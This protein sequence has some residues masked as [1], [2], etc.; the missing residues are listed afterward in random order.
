MTAVT[1]AADRNLLFAILALQMDFI[2]RDQ[3]VA[4]M[5]AWVLEKSKPLG[6]ILVEQKVLRADLHAALQT[7]VEKH[8]EMHGQDAAKSL[9]ALSASSLASHL[10]PLINVAD[11]DVQAS[12]AH[13]ASPLTDDL[14]P[15]V[16][17]PLA[18]RSF[19]LGAASSGARFRILRPHAKGGLGQ[20]F[21][22]HDEELNR[23][24]ALKDIQERFA[25]NAEARTRFLV[26]AEIT[27]GLE[28][29]GIVPVYGLGHHPDGRPF[30]AMRFIR[31]DSLKEAI[32]RYHK[33]L[34]T[35]FAD[36][37]DKRQAGSL[38]S[39]KS[40]KSVD[41]SFTLQFRQLLGRFLDVCNAVAYAHSR[42][43]LHRDLKPGNI[44]L[45]KFG[46][47]L[48]VDWGLAKV[49]G[50]GGGGRGEEEEPPL[51]PASL[52]G[53]TQTM[54]GAAV[55]TPAF[56]SP[57]QAAG[58]LDQLGPATDIY[59]LGATLYVLLTG[60]VP[61]EG[62]DAGEVLRRVQRGD[63]VPLALAPRLSSLAPLAAICQKAMA[64]RPQDRYATV[65]A[66]A[67]DIE[68]W[69]ADEPVSA[70]PEPVLVK[71]GR[72]TRRHKP[73]VSGAAAAL[74]VAL[75]AATAGTLW[76]QNE[77]AR[78]AAD[79]ARRSTEL[80]L[81]REYLNKEVAQALDETAKKRRELHDTLQ[82]PSQVYELLSDIDQWRGRVREARAAWRRARALADGSPELLDQEIGARLGDLE[83]RLADDD[84]DWALAKELD[85]VRLEASTTVEGKFD[86]LRA[87]KKYPV[88]FAKAGLA[89]EQR[90]LALVADRIVR[91][92]GRYA[93]VAAL[94]HWADVTRDKKLLPLLLELARRADSHPWRDRFR[95]LKAWDDLKELE[96]LAK[97]ARPD[98]QSPQV[99]LTL[100]WRIRVKGGDAAEIL[101]RALLY[102]SRDFWLYFEL[103]GRAKDPVERM[104][105]YQAAL[106]VRPQSSTA[107]YSLGNVLYD[108]KDLEGAISHFRKAIQI[109]PNYAFAHTNLGN[110]LSAKKDL[111]GAI[112]HFRKAIQIDPNFAFAH[113]AHNNLGNALKDK[114][115][116]EGAVSHFRKAIQIDPNYAVAHNNLGVVLR[117]KKDLKGAIS[118]FRKAIQIDPNFAAAHNNL[119]VALDAKKDLEG[120]IS[121]FRKAIQIDP[122]LAEP[123]YNLGSALYDKKDLEG[124]ISHTRKAIQINPNYALAHYNLGLAHHDKKDLKGAISHYRKAIQIDPNL[125]LA[126][127]NL[128]LALHQT[129]DLEGAISH[130]SKA[131]QIDPNY[132]QAH[133]NLGV[134]LGAKNDL[135]GAI[136]RFRKAIQIDPNLAQ[137]HSNLGSALYDKK[138]LE[139]AISHFRKAIQI[140]PNFAQ[141]HTGLGIA[142]HAKKDLEGA[143]SHFRKA[144][145][146]DPNDA[147]AHSNLGRTLN[148]NKDP[149]GAI[150]H[151]RKAIQI[152]PNLADPY[153]GMGLALL[154]KGQFAE[155]RTATLQCL[156]LVPGNH[157]LRQFAQ[158]QLTQCDNLLVL[159]GKLVTLVKGGQAPKGIDDCLALADLCRRYKHYYAAAARLYAAAFKLRPAL[160]GDVAKGYRY[161]AACYAALAAAG[162]GLDSQKPDAQQRITLRAQ[163]LDWLRADLEAF[164]GQA[165]A[166]HVPSLL[167]MLDRL[168]HWQKD[169]DL[170]SV[171]E[172]AA[173]SL[174]PAPEH[175]AWKNLWTDAGQLLK[176][177]RAGITET[178]F[179]GT[180]TA[181]ERERSHEL[182]LETGKTY[183]IDLH[184]AAFD[185]Y[186]KLVDAKG[187]MLAENDDIAPDN[188]DARLIFTPPAAGVY[189]IVATSFEQAGR[190]AYVLTL[191]EFRWKN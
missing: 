73:L 90:E 52:S 189:R 32:E 148:A 106:A 162:K 138:D 46:E 147:P 41:H 190:G 110:A 20:V 1:H 33:S 142:L 37:A 10:S 60:H 102:H 125:A 154:R 81:R 139:V 116:L 140:D 114:K 5:N 3:A 45:G 31:G 28:H 94:D 68:H 179:T 144:I 19:A 115:D 93:L 96:R 80:A 105:C 156:K 121:H 123:Y 175:T 65:L 9:A 88:V 82:D 13:L 133:T 92:P 146:I 126:H 57:E 51:R 77:Q 24:V 100:A 18:T 84:K 35:D 6:Q 159:D 134:A 129:K 168:A 53:S 173:L 112:S 177:V 22:A 8:L 43:V 76:Y 161:D 185:A 136:S 108:K 27:G 107:H 69:L 61:F 132:A 164:A 29:P 48:V 89:V 172:P 187:K 67:A 165:R 26:E 163:A 119:G 158:G 183:V 137:A 124:A 117:D 86:Y 56:M 85:D 17:D 54:A 66:L 176:Q 14:S 150:S 4:G 149:E 120:A 128:G 130:Y 98:D 174:L 59:S 16:D 47:T 11:A 95:S 160:A 91:S 71:L 42:G 141:A 166:G 152:D 34:S 63:Y 15:L 113:Y 12:L 104:G 170:A 109:D 74:L 75:L 122:N 36:Y 143:I 2:S 97:E 153:A 64:L 118:H 188:Q 44:M 171:R 39:V 178:R 87:A 23:E 145:E 62:N 169:A 167:L 135:E 49:R 101:R 30:Y 70:W 111:E 127:Y 131:I 181:K 99:M 72:W 186:L 58:R 7:M 21:V 55:G 191:R 184:S 83:R 151:F 78:Q 182:N 155:A 38:K 103:G 180:L 25:G 79:E 40:A 157:P 50:E